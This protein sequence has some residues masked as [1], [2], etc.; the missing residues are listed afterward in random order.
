[1]AA[2]F[3]D[4]L[5]GMVIVKQ[6]STENEALED[7][8]PDEAERFAE[9][10]RKFEFDQFLAPYPDEQLKQWK[11]LSYHISPPLLASLSA[12]QCGFV[13]ASVAPSPIS[14]TNPPTSGPCMY[15]F[16]LVPRH[17]KQPGDCGASLSECNLDKS[18]F[19]QHFIETSFQND[20]NMLLGELQLSFCVFMYGHLFEGFDQWKSLVAMLCQCRTALISRS[21][22]F[23]K[24][25]AVLHRQ[26]KFA[27]DDFFT[28]DLSTSNFLEHSLKR[29]FSSIEDLR[30]SLDKELVDFTARFKALLERKFSTSLVLPDLSHATAASMEELMRMLAE[31]GEDAPALELGPS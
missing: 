16:H 6:W 14:L 24:A 30:G 28:S 27:P 13:K 23:L 15:K 21:K 4:A 20:E 26:L 7:I 3:F 8:D 12:S 25:T 19:L 18:H 31:E 5:P 2:F 1:M 10:V 9:G 11:R 29:F 17:V 22:F